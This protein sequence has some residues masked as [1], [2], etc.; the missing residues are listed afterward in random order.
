MIMEFVVHNPKPTPVPPPT[1]DL[2]GLTEEEMHVIFAMVGGVSG[3]TG[4]RATNSIWDAIH[5]RLGVYSKYYMK[6]DAIEVVLT[7]RNP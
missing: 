1:Y 5:N 2:M 3:N 4:R 6:V 7:V